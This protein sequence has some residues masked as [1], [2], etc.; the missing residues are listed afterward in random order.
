MSNDAHSLAA[1]KGEMA[2][3]TFVLKRTVNTVVS[4]CDNTVEH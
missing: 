2:L 3:L 4:S 1:G